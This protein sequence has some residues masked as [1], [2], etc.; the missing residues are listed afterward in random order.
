MTDLEREVTY[1][2]EFK[3]VLFGKLNI[4]KSDEEINENT[5]EGKVWIK[6]SELNLM[7][8]TGL[9]FLKRSS[10]GKAVFS[11]IKEC[12]GREY[13]NGNSSLAWGKLK[14][15]FDPVSAFSLGKTER[16]FRQRK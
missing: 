13:T 2:S 7:A 3:V 14:K 8:Y 6:S 9:T 4:P 16:A 11:I 1:L 5:E 15:K 12:K 10:S